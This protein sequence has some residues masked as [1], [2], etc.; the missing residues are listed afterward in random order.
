MEATPESPRA[1]RNLDKQELLSYGIIL[2]NMI[3]PSE[4]GHVQTPDYS[5]KTQ[6]ERDANN[7]FH[8]R[9]T[10]V[11]PE[12][13]S[14]QDYFQMKFFSRR[15]SGRQP[16]MLK[17]VWRNVPTLSLIVPQG[18]S[19][20]SSSLRISEEKYVTEYYFNSEGDGIKEEIDLSVETS[21]DI[22]SPFSQKDYGEIDQALKSVE[23][24][25][26]KTL[27]PQQ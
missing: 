5:P 10:N 11:V 8:N 12:D 6:E 19:S 23:S 7:V 1:L 13:K 22:W 18:F 27:N 2:V 15:D 25:E 14:S 4:R 20:P 26:F 24:G 16:I 3:P 9:I 21:R 17:H